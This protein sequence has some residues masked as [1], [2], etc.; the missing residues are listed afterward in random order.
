[1]KKFTHAV[2]IILFFTGC[3]EE[4]GPAGKNTLLNVTI[5]SP[6]SNC[7]NGGFKIETGLDVNADN[8]LSSD[9]IQ[10]SQFLC[11]GTNGMNGTNGLTTL[12]KSTIENSG[13]N[14]VAGGYK[15]QSGIDGNRDGVLQE[16]EIQATQYI[17][18]GTYEK[19][20]RFDFGWPFFGSIGTSS[21]TGE[22]NDI[23]QRSLTLTLTTTQTL[24]RLH[25][26]HICLPLMLAQNVLLNCIIKRTKP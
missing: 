15:I 2:L 6:G 9:E 24:T 26:E 7:V 17:C 20:L 5:E 3:K 21:T 8:I 11:N 16:S 12:L 18:N 10:S 23:K 14:C 19:E 1:M 25:L 22:F 13:V 4:I